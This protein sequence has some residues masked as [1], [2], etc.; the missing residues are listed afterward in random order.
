M[1]TDAATLSRTS[2]SA[3]RPGSGV[4]QSRFWTRFARHR[5]GVASLVILLVL[6]VASAAAPK[7]APYD[8]NR[9]NARALRAPPS[10]AHWLGTDEAGR[11]VLSRLLY[12]GRI[13]LSVGAVASSLAVAIGIMIGMTSGYFGGAV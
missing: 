4:F 1:A 6:A 7:L 3:A 8:P 10:A 2:P 5:L 13:S 9:V 11:D 12:A